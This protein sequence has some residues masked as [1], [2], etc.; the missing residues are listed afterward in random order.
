MEIQIT[1]IKFETVNGKKTGK[2][3]SFKADPKKLA[4]FKTE[5]TLRKKIK[6]YV[7]KSGIFK[8]EELDDVK[9]KKASRDCPSRGIG[10]TGSF[11]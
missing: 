11:S 5:A 6:E 4:V 9:Y 3:F 7:A 8:N 1:A 10:K 2:S